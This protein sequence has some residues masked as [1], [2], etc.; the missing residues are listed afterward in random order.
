MRSAS[1]LG[2]LPAAW[3]QSILDLE[4]AT[5]TTGMPWSCSGGS[6]ELVLSPDGQS[7]ELTVYDTK[8]RVT[9]RRVASPDDVVPTGEAM[10][11]LPLPEQPT[12]ENDR[13]TV[14]PRAPSPPSPPPTP[15]VEPR[16]EARAPR[17]PSTERARLRDVDGWRGPW[18][19]SLRSLGVGALGALPVLVLDPSDAASEVFITSF[20]AGFTVGRRL[21]RAGRL[22]S[23]L[24]FDPSVGAALM[25]YGSNYATRTSSAKVAFWL[26]GGLDATFPVAG[27]FRGVIALEA[28][29]APGLR[30]RVRPRAL[31]PAKSFAYSAYSAGV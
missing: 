17:R 20:C 19:C 21:L 26:G 28:E 31:R 27:A 4:R 11:A 30:S 16:L 14:A 18:P 7:A 29:V 15:R 23:N 3:A 13:A 5:A 2:L 22:D 9:T 24:T 1:P 25:E 12:G 8:G 10:L 6:V